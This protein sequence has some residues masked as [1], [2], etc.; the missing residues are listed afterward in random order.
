VTGVEAL[1][2]WEHPE[3]GFLPPDQF[4]PIVELGDSIIALTNWVI[5]QA[6]SDCR[7]W[8][9]QG[10]DIDVAVNVSTLNIQDEGFVKHLSEKIM[11]HRID[12]GKIQLEI[13]ESVIMADTKRAFKTTSALDAMGIRISIDD[14]GTGYSSLAY[15][16][17]IPVNELKIDKSFVMDM[18]TDEND[19]VI[20]RSTIDLAHN[21][22]LKVTAE[23]VETGGSLD[24][25]DVLRCDSA[26]GFHIC[27]PIPA[28]KM[29]S[30]VSEW[31]GKNCMHIN[32][33]DEKKFD[34]SA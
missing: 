30:W 4:I 16:K 26:Q 33:H 6:F 1:V 18:E 7:K 9:D 10:I 32:I 2:R 25:L 34:Q 17:K 13:T 19:A 24:L 3:H 12:P 20:V 8:Q 29:A 5:N 11:E 15:I 14:F 21:L 28:E 23:G 27:R 22:G 31:Q